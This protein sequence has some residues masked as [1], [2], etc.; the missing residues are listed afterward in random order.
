MLL[1]IEYFPICKK[2]ASKKMDMRDKIIYSVWYNWL[3][4]DLK[5]VHLFWER[6][7][8]GWPSNCFESTQAMFYKAVKKWRSQKWSSSLWDCCYLECPSVNLAGC[9]EYICI[10]T[11][12]LFFPIYPQMTAKRSVQSKAVQNCLWSA[13][14]AQCQR[15][16]HKGIYL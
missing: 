12:F 5:I 6:R 9:Q 3:T 11:F 2:N 4:E 13:N 14:S 1:L 15:K 8:C 10:Q 7:Y 16:E